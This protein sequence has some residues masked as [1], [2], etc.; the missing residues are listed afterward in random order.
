MGTY[1][2]D[3]YKMK[4]CGERNH[5]TPFAVETSKMQFEKIII[6]KVWFDIRSNS[7]S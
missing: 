7:A 3:K 4:E 6:H 1:I 5:N 2:L